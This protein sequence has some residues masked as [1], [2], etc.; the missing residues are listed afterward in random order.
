MNGRG[1][2][3]DWEG[4]VHTGLGGKCSHGIGREVFTRDWEGN[5]HMGLGGKC[6]HGIGGEIGEGKRWGVGEGWEGWLVC[7]DRVN[8]F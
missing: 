6:S 5:V 7:S 1:F 2:I 4:S 8:G 3:W